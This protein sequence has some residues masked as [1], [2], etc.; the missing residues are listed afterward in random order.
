MGHLCRATCTQNLISAQNSQK[1]IK[2]TEANEQ[3]RFY[4]LNTYVQY[5]H[6]TYIGTYCK[7][8]PDLSMYY[9][10]KNIP[11]YNGNQPSKQTV[12][13]FSSLVYFL[14]NVLFTPTR[15]Q[16]LSD[17]NVRAQFLQIFTLKNGF[18]P[19]KLKKKIWQPFCIDQSTTNPAQFFLEYGWIG[20]ADA[21][22]ILIFSIF[23][24]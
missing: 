6:S 20:C 15:D 17:K 16:K 3:L 14:A 21:P 5:A 13:S 9:S 12:Y 8:V 10:T 18:N 2:C 1:G 7:V 4:C 19:G 23:K 22:T 24:G 11:I